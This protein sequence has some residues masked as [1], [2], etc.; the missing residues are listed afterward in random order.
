VRHQSSAATRD[1]RPHAPSV[2]VAGKGCGG[3]W[4]RRPQQWFPVEVWGKRRQNSFGEAVARF[5][6]E[7]ADSVLVQ[8]RRAVL[9]CR[10]PSL[11]AGS[12]SGGILTDGGDR[13]AGRRRREARWPAAERGTLVGGGERRAA[14]GRIPSIVSK[15]VGGIRW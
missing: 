15:E 12:W 7:A 14:L 13:R 4:H 11:A 2:V 10:G 9:V 1:I 6:G 5:R 8:K 3:D